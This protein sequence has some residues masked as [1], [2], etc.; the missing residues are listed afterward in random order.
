MKGG[1][2]YSHRTLNSR[3]T[4]S[5]TCRMYIYVQL[6]KRTAVSTD[7]PTELHPGISEVHNSVQDINPQFLIQFLQN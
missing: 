1:L 4:P 6:V 2:A 5:F 3:K 7:E